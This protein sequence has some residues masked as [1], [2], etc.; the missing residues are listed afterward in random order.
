MVVACFKLTS[1]NIPEQIEES[2]N[3]NQNTVYSG[4][5]EYE[6]KMVSIRP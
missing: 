1:Q 6:K 2:E 5:S 3:V 4:L